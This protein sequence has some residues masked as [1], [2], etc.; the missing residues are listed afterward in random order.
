[1]ATGAAIASAIIG[2]GTAAHGA[3][4]AEKAASGEEYRIKEAKGQALKKRKT[5]I[6]TQR[7]QLGVGSDGFKLNQTGQ[8]GIAQQQEDLLG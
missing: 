5:L 8:T 2:A 1:M 4:E 7:K 6:D 3:R